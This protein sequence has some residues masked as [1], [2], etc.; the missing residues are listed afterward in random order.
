[1]VVVD[2]HHLL[3]SYGTLQR[4]EVQVAT[5][6]VELT[7]EADA[8]VGHRLGEVTI[9]DPH[10]IA[11][12]GSAVHPAL[13]PAHQPEAEV[14]GTVYALTDEQLARADE[15]EVDAYTRVEV[16]LRSGRTAWVYAPRRHPGRPPRR[17]TATTIRPPV[18]PRAGRRRDVPSSAGRR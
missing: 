4:P 15:Y 2:D 8:V 11:V 17:S 3:F 16:L 6:G 13:V 10:V 9:E 14:A 18:R 7:G 12:S 5:F 1:L